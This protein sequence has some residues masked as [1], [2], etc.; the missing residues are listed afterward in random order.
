MGITNYKWPAAILPCEFTK[1][2]DEQLLGKKNSM[3]ISPRFASLETKMATGIHIMY[4]G[5]T[6]IRM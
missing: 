3:Q 4:V 6:Y 2:L 5:S 1:E